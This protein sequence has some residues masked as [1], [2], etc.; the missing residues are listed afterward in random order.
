M[1]NYQVIHFSVGEISMFVASSIL[2]RTNPCVPIAVSWGMP[3]MMV[4]W[5]W[6]EVTPHQSHRGR[7]WTCLGQQSLVWVNRNLA[8]FSGHLKSFGAVMQRLFL[9]A[10]YPR[11]EPWCWHIFTYKTGHFLGQMLG[12]I[13]QH[14]GSHM[15]IISQM[16]TPGVDLQVEAPEAPKVDPLF[17]R[18]RPRG[19]VGVFVVS[20]GFWCGWFRW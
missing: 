19:F 4:T 10:E 18:T 9:K 17:A 11:C 12:F 8:V 3:F 1:L 16:W 15:G 20:G 14:H 7:V 2:W 13:F 6:D 5:W